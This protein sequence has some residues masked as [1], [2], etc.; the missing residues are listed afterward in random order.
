MTDRLRAAL[1]AA[2][3]LGTT[4]GS[5]EHR[6]I[7]AVY[8]GIKPLPRGY[9][10]TEKDPWCAGFVSAAAVMAGLGEAYPLE[11]SCARIIEIA[12]GMG[13]WVEEDG[14]MPLVGDWVL[15]DWQAAGDGE[16]TGAPDHVGVVIGTE[17]GQILVVEGNYDN[18]VKLRKIPVN[19]EK[20]R[21]FVCP[22][23]EEESAMRY[24]TLSEIP[25]FARKTIEKLI[26][27]GSLSGYS[28]EDLGLTEEM[29]RIFVILDRRGK[30]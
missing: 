8:N 17:A 15:Y 1:A 11:C 5:R 10:L 21:G 16:C 9:R 25:A 24:R 23:W 18:Q 26:R 6:E 29:I 30:L 7:L 28:E 3:W 27:D 4:E 20:I 22:G 13:I 19:D 14:H 2:R 12:K